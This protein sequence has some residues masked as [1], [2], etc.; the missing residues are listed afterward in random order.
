MKTDV[1]QET[2]GAF[3]R[4]THV[5]LEGA[6]SGPLAGLE[7]GAKDVFDVA[8]NKSAAYSQQC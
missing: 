8:D 2:L 5:A 1:L 6:A 7:F 4:E 3:C